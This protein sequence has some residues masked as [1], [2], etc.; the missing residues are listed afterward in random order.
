MTLSAQIEH[1]FLGFRLA[2]AFSVGRPGL[3]A[4]FGPSG[5]GKSTCINAI[6]GL[7]KP[8]SGHIEINGRVVFDSA[9]GLNL[10]ARQR[11]IGYVFQDARL[12][13][14]LSV[15]RNLD[16]GARRSPEPPSP[17]ERAHII[18]MLGIGHLLE[19]RPAGLSGGERQ[20]VALGRALL[21]KP[22]LLLLDEPLA[23]LDQARKAEV[24]PHLE[25]LRDEARIPIVLVSHAL[26][27]VA[28]LADD[29]VVVNEGRSVAAG[30][31]DEIL[32]RLDLLP[33]TGQSEPMSVIVADVLR[34]DAEG[35]LT[36][37]GFNGGR[38]WVARIGADPGTQVR[39]RI[40]ARDV[41]LALEPPA[42][43]SA[44]NMI[45]G[46]VAE[47]GSGPGPY[48]DIRLVCGGSIL[49]ARITRRSAE[50]LGLGPGSAVIAVIKAVSVNRRAGA[51]ALNSPVLNPQV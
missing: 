34:H 24:L 42:R 41:M 3:T 9:S 50:R 6:S 36:E 26:D 19:R 27:D 1:G 11:R 30:P 18:E 8:E 15:N 43:I 28:R 23:A 44:T 13:P 17:A 51:A 2:M 38:L 35:G 32:S 49:L 33:L 10:P 29:I 31:V 25:R 47:I 5:S 40:A 22:S 12:F 7:L 48:C 46:R 16:F 4:L 20:R 21:M 39:L 45:Q 14:H 37:L